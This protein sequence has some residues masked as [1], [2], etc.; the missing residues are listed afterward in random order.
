MKQVIGME[1]EILLAAGGKS[2]EGLIS[3]SEENRSADHSIALRQ[4]GNE[5]PHVTSRAKQFPACLKEPIGAW[6]D[7]IA[8]HRLQIN[9]V[10]LTKFCWRLRFTHAHV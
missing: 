8:A 5:Q 4:P 2:R 7:T 6:R 9:L 1:V 3:V 10:P